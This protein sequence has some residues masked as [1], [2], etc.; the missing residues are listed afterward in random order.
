MPKVTI[1]ITQ[2]DNDSYFGQ[3]LPTWRNGFCKIE[4]KLYPAQDELGVYG[5]GEYG[6]IKIGSRF[7]FVNGVGDTWDIDKWA[8][9][10]W[11]PSAEQDEAFDSRVDALPRLQQQ[12]GAAYTLHQVASKALQ[13]ASGDAH[14]VDW[15]QVHQDV[16]AKAVGQDKQPAAAVLEAIKRHSPG[17]ITPEQIAAVD[18]THAIQRLADVMSEGKVLPDSGPSGP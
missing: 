11:A 18:K 3:K 8:P 17:A 12:A 5:A 10:G 4:R 2:A 1:H 6:A 9:V 15:G 16:F 14:A 7:A 13:D